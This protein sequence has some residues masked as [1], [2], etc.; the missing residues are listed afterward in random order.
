MN[1]APWLIRVGTN[2]VDGLIAIPLLETA[3]VFD[4]PGVPRLIIVALAVPAIVL[5]GYTAGM[6]PAGLLRAGAAR[7]SGSDWW[8]TAPAGTSG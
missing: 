6:W 5:F 7:C 2:T 8:T 3:Q 1:Y 4:T